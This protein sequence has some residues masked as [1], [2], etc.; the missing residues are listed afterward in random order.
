MGPGFDTSTIPAAS[1]PE[2]FRDGRGR[3]LVLIQTFMDEVEFDASGCEMK[4]TKYRT[5]APGKPR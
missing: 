3:G 4:L 5:D 2:S 1:D